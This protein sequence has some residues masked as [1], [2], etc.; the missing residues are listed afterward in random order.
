MLPP[1]SQSG[2][3][4][5][6][7]FPAE[8]AATNGPEPALKGA[9]LKVFGFHVLAQDL[10]LRDV[11]FRIRAFRVSGFGALGFWRSGILGFRISAHTAMGIVWSM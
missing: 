1:V 2:E 9:L 6:E 5:A 8:T 10:G 7:K 3:E 11:R 4:P